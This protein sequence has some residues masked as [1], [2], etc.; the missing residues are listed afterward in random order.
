MMISIKF[1]LYQMFHSMKSTHTH[2]IQRVLA[3]SYRLEALG[4]YSR[5]GDSLILKIFTSISSVAPIRESEIERDCLN[6]LL[7]RVMCDIQIEL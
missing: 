1:G 4:I 7:R 6:D 2:W 5:I 3:M